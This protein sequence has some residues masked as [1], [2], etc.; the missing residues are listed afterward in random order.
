MRSISKVKQLVGA[1]SIDLLDRTNRS[2]SPK[3][4]EKFP[5]INSTHDG[6][7]NL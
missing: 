5:D 4:D 3:L 7:N 2:L 1:K 6:P